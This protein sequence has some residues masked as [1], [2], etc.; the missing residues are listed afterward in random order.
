METATGVRSAV[1]I[2]MRSPKWLSSLPDDHVDGDIKRENP[3]KPMG[4][5]F[6]SAGERRRIEI[7]S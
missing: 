3:H 1:L 2:L 5:M 4:E 6:M 7:S